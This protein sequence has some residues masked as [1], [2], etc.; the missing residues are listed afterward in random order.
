MYVQVE[1]LGIVFH[2][3]GGVAATC[4]IFIF[5]GALLIRGPYE[6]MQR[7]AMEADDQSTSLRTDR[8]QIL[9]TGAGGAP[10][11]EDGDIELPS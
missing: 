3:L 7:K 1:D 5:P 10:N 4:L 6:A 2:I 11:H 8:Y 9:A